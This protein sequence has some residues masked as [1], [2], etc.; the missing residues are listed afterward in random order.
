MN[1]HRS[2]V[3]RV[4]NH[5]QLDNFD[6][7]DARESLH[8]RIVEIE[9]IAHAAGGAVIHLPAAASPAQRRTFS[10]IYTLVSRV[11]TDVSNAVVHGDALVAALAAHLHAQRGQEARGDS[12]E[13]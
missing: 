2:T 7:G 5:P 6:P 9:A 13:S 1:K 3:A 10:R 11:A 8:T 4:A 12:A